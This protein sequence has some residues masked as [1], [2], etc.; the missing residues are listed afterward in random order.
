MTARLQVPGPAS[1]RTNRRSDRHPQAFF[2]QLT[3]TNAPQ[4]GQ[5]DG[6]GKAVRML[7]NRNWHAAV[8]EPSRAPMIASVCHPCTAE[9]PSRPQG[10]SARPTAM[11]TRQQPSEAGA[12][13]GGSDGLPLRSGRK[14]AASR[15]VRISAETLTC[16][17]FRPEHQRAT[18]VRALLGCAG[19]AALHTQPFAS[20]SAAAFPMVCGT[21]P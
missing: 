17:R 19:I 20:R 1:K 8:R 11:P 14:Y 10:I 7:P 13:R 6:G 3:K 4:L 5:R 2:G 15:P 9:R 12:D 18:K 16:P 21:S